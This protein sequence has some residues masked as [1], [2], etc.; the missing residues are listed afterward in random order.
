MTLRSLLA[1]LI[2]RPRPAPV[3]RSRPNPFHAVTVHGQ[4]DA[5]RPLAGRRFLSKDAPTLPLA[6]CDEP[7]GCTCVYRHHP[8]RRVGNPRRGFVS[9]FGVRTERRRSNGRRLSED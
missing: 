7:G 4:C 5:A 8:D 9:D 1:P 6:G 3:T 2:S